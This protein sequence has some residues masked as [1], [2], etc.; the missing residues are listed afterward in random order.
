MTAPARR[1]RDEPPGGVSLPV[2]PR[3]VWPL[4][5]L[6]GE[7]AALALVEHASGTPLY[8]PREL[9]GGDPDYWLVRLVGHPLARILVA[10][11]GGNYLRPPVARAWLIQIYRGRGMSY[12]DIC[13]ALRCSM[14]TVGAVLNRADMTRQGDLFGG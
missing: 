13:R 4:I 9:P 10:E 5:R 7:D 1:N 8:I 2:A 14:S 6:V 12:T 3:A 11:Y